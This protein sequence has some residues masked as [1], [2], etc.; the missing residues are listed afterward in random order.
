MILNAFHVKFDDTQNELPPRACRPLNKTKKKQQKKHQKINPPPA[1][2]PERRVRGAP[3]PREEK[4]NSATAT[5]S[6]HE[7]NPVL[8]C[9]AQ[10][11]DNK[12]SVL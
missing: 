10:V 1:R 7:Y 8:T 9:V 3:A 4:K 6:V 12:V 5:A 11:L 2:P